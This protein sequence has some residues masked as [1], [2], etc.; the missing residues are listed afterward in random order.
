MCLSEGLM[1]RKGGDGHAAL[2]EKQCSWADDLTASAA[3]TLI[4]VVRCS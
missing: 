3:Q 4:S 1:R 2:L